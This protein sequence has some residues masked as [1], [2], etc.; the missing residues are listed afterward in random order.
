MWRTGYVDSVNLRAHMPTMKIH[1]QKNVQFMRYAINDG[2][3]YWLMLGNIK[4]D[5][6]RE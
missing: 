3:S 6:A 4:P 1:Q 2:S 5:L